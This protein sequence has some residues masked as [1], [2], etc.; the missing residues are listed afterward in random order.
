MSTQNLTQKF[1]ARNGQPPDMDNRTTQLSTQQALVIAGRAC[2]SILFG[3]PHPASFDRTDL[4]QTLEILTQMAAAI[5]PA[6]GE[7]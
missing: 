3:E 1:I 2:N 7:V 4:S 6:G 5:E